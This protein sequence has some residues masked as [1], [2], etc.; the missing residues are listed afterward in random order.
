M[1]VS[2]AWQSRRQDGTARQPSHGPRKTPDGPSVRGRPSC[3]RNHTSTVAREPGRKLRSE[4]VPRAGQGSPPAA[5]ANRR[6]KAVRGAVVYS[7]LEP[8][9]P[10]KA[11]RREVFYVGV[12]SSVNQ[13][14][15]KG[16]QAVCKSRCHPH[17]A[18]VGRMAFDL[19]GKP[20][21]RGLFSNPKP[22]SQV[23][24]RIRFWRK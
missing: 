14:A 10:E 7:D 24:D 8:V 1:P 23:V 21:N 3:D 9:R 18:M 2:A 20:G 17:H 11:L 13:W 16:L 4:V 15:G 6:I 22:N 5:Q 12:E 19:R